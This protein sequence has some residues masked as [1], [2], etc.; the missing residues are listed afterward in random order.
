VRVVCGC[1]YLAKVQGLGWRVR[2]CEVEG[3]CE[4][5][6]ECRGWA[7]LAEVEGAVVARSLTR[8]DSLEEGD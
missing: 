3:E 7:D 1:T 5:W 6:G 2:V 4:G 8:L